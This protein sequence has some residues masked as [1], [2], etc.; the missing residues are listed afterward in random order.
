MRWFQALMP[1]EEQFVTLFQRHATTLVDGSVA[2]RRLLDGGPGI[3]DACAEIM[4]HEE[5]ADD[6]AR[7]TLEAVR[8]TFVTPFDRSDIKALAGSLDDAIDQM[9]KTAKAAMLFEVETFDPQMRE[10]GD[11]IV[12]CAELTMEAM[13]L[14]RH[15][16]KNSA[17]LHAI[18]EEIVRIEGMSDDLNDQGMKALFQASRTSSDPM[19]YIVGAEIYDHLEKVV[20]RFEDVANRVSAILIEH[21]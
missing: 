17:R 21:L 4:R 9:Q 1:K 5:A 20:D 11:Q 3:K 15:M 10:M 7:E 2:L 12:R 8:R 18:S 6:I 13:A 16:Q 14:M 19:R